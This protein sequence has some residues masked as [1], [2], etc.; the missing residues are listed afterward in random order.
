MGKFTLGCG[1]VFGLSAAFFVTRLPRSCR[2]FKN[3]S[4]EYRSALLPLAKGNKQTLPGVIP[5]HAAWLRAESIS[6]LALYGRL[7]FKES[8]YLA[9]STV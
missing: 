3:L 5:K 1:E 2:A 8:N 7:L 4:L 6:S 9:T